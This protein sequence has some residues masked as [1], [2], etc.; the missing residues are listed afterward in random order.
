[1][2]TSTPPEATGTTQT[3]SPHSAWLRCLDT[4][5][6]APTR[7]ICFPHAGG[8]ASVFRAW[9]SAWDAS[10]EL[11]AVQYP[12]RED[13]TTESMPGTLSDLARHIA[14]TLQWKSDKP[15][16]F[17]GHSLGAVVAYETASQLSRLGLTTPS[18]LIA[19]GSPPPGS[20]AEQAGQDDNAESVQWLHDG[21]PPDA[22]LQQAAAR[23]LAADLDL[24][25]RYPQRTPTPLDIPLTVL[26][27]RD[28]PGLDAGALA[29]W[30][31]YTTC[32][33]DTVTL[34][35]DHFACYEQPHVILAELR[36]SSPAPQSP[37]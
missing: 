20:A 4:R 16:A 30:D 25:A 17:F 22:E 1:M 14:L 21:P 26:R 27:N 37:R 31:Q 34:P 23:V 9:L 29:P 5:P 15:F 7:L 33:V 10:T 36:K 2:T 8:S 24:L 12:G 28:D 3:P 11:W 6:D 32:G 18:R 19:S 35:G 13:R